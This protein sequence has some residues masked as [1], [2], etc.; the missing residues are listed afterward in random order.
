ARFRPSVIGQLEPGRAHRTMAA[1]QPCFVIAPPSQAV[2]PPANPER[3]RRYMAPRARPGARQAERSTAAEIEN[4]LR[5][6]RGPGVATA[7]HP[8]FCA[9]TR[10][11]APRL[12]LNAA[13]RA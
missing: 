8:K 4:R 11:E 9:E 6:R 13:G 7:S 12:R 3:F 5:K 1:R 10:D 2:E